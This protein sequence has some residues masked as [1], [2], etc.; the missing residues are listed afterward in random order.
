MKRRS[1]LA[2]ILVLSLLTAAFGQQPSPPAPVQQEPQQE[3]DNEVVRITTNLVQL[4][5]VV[6]DKQGKLVTDLLPEE[7]EIFEDD[8]PQKI[9]NF[10]YIST[11]SGTAQPVL[12]TKSGPADKNAP[13][14]PPVRLRPEQVRRTIALIVDDLNLS[15]VSTYYVRRALKNFVEKQMQPG[16]LVAIIRTAGGMGALQQFTSDK[17]QLQAAIERVKFSFQG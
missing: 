14:V 17:R 12:T 4:D 13:P 8:R 15:F 3:D 1:A 16:D 7:V 9:T 10:S 5:A 2:L 11:E 6:T